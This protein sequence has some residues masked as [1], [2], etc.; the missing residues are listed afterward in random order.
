MKFILKNVLFFF[1][2][3]KFYVSIIIEFWN[4][5]WYSLDIYSSHILDGTS[6]Q[7]VSSGIGLF[8]TMKTKII[9]AL[10]GFMEREEYQ[11][12]SKEL[13]V[14]I[15]LFDFCRCRLLSIIPE[16]EYFRTM[17]GFLLF[18]SIATFCLIYLK[19]HSNVHCVH[20]TYTKIFWMQRFFLISIQK[21]IA[22]CR[23]FVSKKSFSYWLSFYLK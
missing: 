12:I 20:C 4:I 2:N 13:V 22:S 21:K 17:E 14:C 5:I 7:N 8:H 11:N 1:Q 15:F 6:L 16:F 9:C 19:K 23:I 10:F 3:T 18:Q